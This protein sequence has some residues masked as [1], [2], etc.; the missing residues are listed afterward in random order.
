MAAEALVETWSLYG[1]G[2][3]IIWAR[4]LCRWRMVGVYNFKPDDYLVWLAWVRSSPSL[5]YH[6]SPTISHRDDH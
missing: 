6:S 2:T 5:S 1:V 4:V 3:L